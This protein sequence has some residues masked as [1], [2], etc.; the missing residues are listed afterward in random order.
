MLEGELNPR[1]DIP[2]QK[3]RSRALVPCPDSRA[4]ALESGVQACVA[5]GDRAG[6]CP[7]QGMAAGVSTYDQVLVALWL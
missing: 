3:E 1:C 2:R 4:A 6:R 5:D 7:Y